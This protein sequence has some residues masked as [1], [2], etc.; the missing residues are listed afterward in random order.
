[1]E[2]EDPR[3]GA[4]SSLCAGEFQQDG[5]T[6]MQRFLELRPSAGVYSSNGNPLLANTY[7]NLDHVTRIECGQGS[8]YLPFADEIPNEVTHWIRLSVREGS[9]PAHVI[10]YFT[11]QARE[12]YTRI[13]S[14]INESTYHGP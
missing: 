13:L 8:L 10:L 7:V 4:S 3:Y 2:R 12:E 1:M 9:E 14:I 5:D 11:G 6:T